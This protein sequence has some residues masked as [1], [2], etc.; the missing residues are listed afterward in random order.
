MMTNYA[1]RQVLNSGG[2]IILIPYLLSLLPLLLL[3]TYQNISLLL[4][5]LAALTIGGMLDDLLGDSSSK[6]LIGHICAFMQGNMS[7]G[8]LKALLGSLTGFLLAWTKDTKL[9]HLLIDTCLFAFTV[10][11]INLLDLRPGR[12]IK[13]FGLLLILTETFS[14]FSHIHFVLPVITLLVLY[15]KGEMK[16]LYMLGDAGASLL[17]GILGFYW[18]SFLNT[19]LKGIILIF[20]ILLHLFAEFH[21][22]SYYIEK[23]P[24]F[25]KI[26]AL[27]R[28]Y[29]DK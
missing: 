9:I 1:G 3:N 29:D 5:I 6:G 21:S 23:Y 4:I 25:K 22:L 19:I 7:T 8:I 28:K 18:V 27:G 26:D 20:I 13:G 17:G 11:L 14:R 16:E 24:F 10:N 15:I 12:A 2:L